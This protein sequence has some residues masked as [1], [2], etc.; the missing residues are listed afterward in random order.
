MCTNLLRTQAAEGQHEIVSARTMDFGTITKPFPVTLKPDVVVYPRNTAFP[1]KNKLEEKLEETFKLLPKN[2]LNW[3]NKYGFVAV[4]VGPCILSELPIKIQDLSPIFLDGMN[5]KGLSAASLWLDGS[6]YQAE[7]DKDDNLMFLNVV[8]YALGMCATVDDVK[9]ALS[10]ITV[11]SPSKFLMN[12]PAHFIFIDADPAHDALVVEYTDGAPNFYDVPNGVLTNEPA[13]PKMLTE[14]EKYKDLTVYQQNP[15]D[16]PGLLGLPADASP[17][18][19]FVRS[20][21]FVESTN[22]PSNS[23]DAISLTEVIIQNIQVP[24]GTVVQKSNGEILDYSQWAVVR[25]HIN[26]IFYYKTFDNQ[27]LKKLDVNAIDF[28]TTQKI[29]VPI[30]KG[31]WFIDMTSSY[32]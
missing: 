8:G 15:N 4:D 25:D 21:K 29:S 32:T 26:G 16:T 1:V 22:K 5:E 28:A 13:Y 24:L 19:R 23:Q 11:T 6:Q 10:S 14:L 20:T 31:G 30:D 7:S 2:P 17:I 3:Q 18:S 27:T 12:Y 9:T